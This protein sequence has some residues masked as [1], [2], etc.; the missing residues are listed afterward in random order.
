TQ[1]DLAYAAANALTIL[2]YAGE[3]L[4]TLSLKEIRVPGADLSRANLHLADC[5][6]G[7]FSGVDFRG[8]YLEGANFEGAI[9]TDC[10]WGH[11]LEIEFEHLVTALIYT[12][13]GRRLIVGDNIGQIHFV[14]TESYLIERTVHKRIFNLSEENSI[15]C[16]AIDGYS[17]QSAQGLQPSKYLALGN[18]G[19]G[20]YLW[21]IDDEQ[22]TGKFE[23]N[24]KQAKVTTLIFLSDGQQLASAREKDNTICLWD[25][26]TKKLLG[27]LTGHTDSIRCLAYSP[28]NTQLASGSDD[29][30]VRL[31]EVK[32]LKSRILKG[33]T[34]RINCLAYSSDGK[35]L[36][37]AS[38]D[39]TLRLWD[40]STDK[41]LSLIQATEVV[42]FT[43]VTYTADIM[44]WAYGDN[45]G[46]VHLLDKAFENIKILENC[47]VFNLECLAYSSL[48]GVLAWSGSDI[49]RNKKIFLRY[50]QIG[51][52]KNENRH[53]MSIE[54]LAYSPCDS[55]IASGSS[56]SV[57]IWDMV[58]ET[59]QKLQC[60]V[61]GQKIAFSPQGA[62]LAL[63][64]GYTLLLYDI[65]ENK[66]KISYNNPN[67]FNCLAYAPCGEVLAMG[68][69]SSLGSDRTIQFLDIKNYELKKIEKVDDYIDSLVFV[70]NG[71]MIAIGYY[72]G[73]IH[74]RDLATNKKKWLIGLFGKIHC[75]AYSSKRMEVAAG[76]LRGA[77]RTWDISNTVPKDLEGHT[78]TV[79]CLAY[80]PDGAVLVSGGYRDVR[81]WDTAQ[82]ICQQV[83]ELP[84]RLLA[85]K[86]VDTRLH[87]GM[88][89]LNNTV[90]SFAYEKIN[91]VYQLLSIFNPAAMPIYWPRPFQQ[92]NIKQTCGLT[93]NQQ[94]FLTYQGAVGQP[95]KTKKELVQSIV[96]QKEECEL[97]QL[98]NI[99]LKLL[100]AKEL[101]S[102]T[103]SVPNAAR[104]S[105]FNSAFVINCQQWQAYIIR[106]HLNSNTNNNK[107]TIAADKPVYAVI[108]G[109][110]LSGESLFI[111]FSL[112]Q[113][114][115]DKQYGRV[116]TKCLQLINNTSHEHLKTKVLELF[117]FEKQD[118]FT[119]MDIYHAGFLSLTDVEDLLNTLIYEAARQQEGKP[120]NNRIIYQSELPT[121]NPYIVAYTNLTWLRSQLKGYSTV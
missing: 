1:F 44:M 33:H 99:K 20:I 106:S 115:V 57:Q 55:K 108:E 102:Q 117:T 82:G 56:D 28:Q 112:E 25:V 67:G 21:Q 103:K 3:T 78:G 62:E 73:L 58:L 14:N 32:T 77:L 47:Y 42:S 84:S 116:N 36:V 91:N 109:I 45:K 7:D 87:I 23:Y 70:A 71:K 30:T 60:D 88:T 118:S 17:A 40:A 89:G 107:K 66:K 2:H 24:D 5:R 64:N 4:S 34:K 22:Y 119:A 81:I 16:L 111:R 65:A 83:I 69:G 59:G 63:T 27:N 10:Q 86:W 93:L 90:L 12:T 104:T 35:K 110:N 94:Q 100:Q 19:G 92:M 98:A 43:C 95:K 18:A 80:S 85:L 37:S 79:I 13:D 120:D 46:G 38:D 31:W 68:V 74:L 54:C 11:P 39:G 9:L 41:Q 72:G 8:A 113:D 48:S 50:T 101:L 53:S 49:S 15:T 29:M 105:L 75:L 96:L 26:N 51:E 114:G 97:Q 52:A 76:A 6:N 61:G 121:Q